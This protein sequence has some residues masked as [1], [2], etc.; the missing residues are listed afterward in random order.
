MPAALTPAERR[1]VARLR[2]PAQVQAWL[3]DG[4]AYNHDMR[5][6]RSFRGVLAHK[7]AHCLE[8]AL[9]AAFLLEHHGHPPLLL[10]LESADKL[11]HVVFVFRGRDGRWGAVGKS[12]YPALMG[13]RPVYRTLRDLAWSYVDPF[14]DRTGRVTGWALFDLRAWRGA[15]WRWDRGHVWRI[16]RA[17]LAHPH[18]PLKASDARHRLWKRRYLAWKAEHPDAEPSRSFYRDSSRMM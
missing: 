14:V 15:D 16:E 4:I 8:G 12:R 13:R 10:D 2:T 7:S 18:A 3:R 17:L 6:L 9:A 5:S 11:D 1:L